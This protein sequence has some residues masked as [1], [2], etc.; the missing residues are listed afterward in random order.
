MVEIEK[1]SDKEV[2]QFFSQAFDSV[3]MKVKA[4]AMK[5]M[6]QFSSGLP[7]LMH[8]IGDA[9]FWVDSD[10]IIDKRILLRE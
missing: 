8:E 6:V 7:L 2:E 10:G 4:E 3:G 1:L 5:L 9:V